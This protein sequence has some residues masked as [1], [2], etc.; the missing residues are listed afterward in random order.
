[1]FYFQYQHQQGAYGAVFAGRHQSMGVCAVK[2]ADL[3]EG[4]LATLLHRDGNARVEHTAEDEE[5]AM[6]AARARVVLSITMREIAMLQR[7]SL[8][9]C[10]SMMRLLG[11]V[12]QPL[13]LVLE[14]C[15]AG[16]LF[17]YLHRVCWLNSYFKV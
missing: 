5:Q 17:D 15:N 9:K 11:V 2:R 12:A 3:D 1:M 13:S 7:A 8:P 4:A 14:L 10:S 6:L 16:S